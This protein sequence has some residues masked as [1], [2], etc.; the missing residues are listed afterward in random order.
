MRTPVDCLQAAADTPISS[1]TRTCHEAVIRCRVAQ[2]SRCVH[3]QPGR[4]NRA[5]R[6]RPTAGRGTAAERT[7][8]RGCRQTAGDRHGTAARKGK[9]RRCSVDCSHPGPVAAVDG[10]TGRR[11]RTWELP[12]GLDWYCRAA[13][14]AETTT[15]YCLSRLSA[16][17]IMQQFQ[18]HT[19]PGANV[20]RYK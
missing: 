9:A 15:T 5:G 10:W 4:G 19:N 20:T 6:P 17:R 8:G 3:T 11:I 16:Q 13:T 7:V 18:N 1:L 12:G 14:M 2:G